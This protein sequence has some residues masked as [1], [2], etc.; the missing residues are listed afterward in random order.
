MPGMAAEGE[1]T[2]L[3]RDVESGREGALDELMALVYADLERMAGS[4]LRKHYGQ[5]AK[6]ITLEPAALVNESFLKL[7]RQRNKYDNRGPFFSIATRMMLRVL[8]DDRR[9]REA[10]MRGGGGT[11]ITLIIDDQQV[12]GDEPHNT[13]I[14]VEQLADALEKLEGLS[15]RKADI[16]KM[17]VVWG[18]TLE[19]IA[20]SL[21]VS[22][23]TVDRDWR[24][25][26]AWLAEEVR[27]E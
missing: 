18:L 19:Q 12:A 7:I 23:S 20:Q 5:H 4:Y 25:S 27:A 3:L 21:D 13:A 15:P 14:E 10:R 26:K 2:R 17:R 6:S 22:P 1:I 16:V 9:R 8:I 11:H 24:F